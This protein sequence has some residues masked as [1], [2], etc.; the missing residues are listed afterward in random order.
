MGTANIQ[1]RFRHACDVSFLLLVKTKNQ[2]GLV[3]LFENFRHN[4]EDLA[5][6][7][8]HALVHI[9]GGRIVGGVHGFALMSLM[10]CS[11]EQRFFCREQAFWDNVCQKTIDSGRG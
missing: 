10:S 2:E 8:F 9:C 11:M 7:S 1:T 3:R 5:H 4:H 6:F